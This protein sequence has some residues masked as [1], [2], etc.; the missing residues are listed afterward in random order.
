LTP[1]WCVAFDRSAAN[2]TAFGLG[3]HRRVPAINRRS[4]NRVAVS[5]RAHWANHFTQAESERSRACCCFR[6]ITWIHL[7]D[8]PAPFIR[9]F[10][11]PAADVSGAAAHTRAAARSADGQLV[12][13]RDHSARDD[14]RNSGNGN[15]THL[16]SG[17]RYSDLRSSRLGSPNQRFRRHRGLTQCYQGR[18]QDPLSTHYGTMLVRLRGCRPAEG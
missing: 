10:A 9:L 15:G 4:Q 12:Q 11:V 13:P 17:F 1:F 3:P 2:G 7:I 18:P 5:F 6:L 8:L 16:Q 14:G